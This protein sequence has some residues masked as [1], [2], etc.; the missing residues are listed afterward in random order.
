MKNKKL[1]VL[2]KYLFLMEM[3]ILENLVNLLRRATLQKCFNFQMEDNIFRKLKENDKKRQI[4]NK[5]G[6]TLGHYMMILLFSGN[7]KSL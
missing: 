1:K 6:K 5:E 2:N 7:L 4:I 3:V